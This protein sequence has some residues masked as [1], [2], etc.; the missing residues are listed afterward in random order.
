[1]ST[2]V[3]RF[4]LDM[5]RQWMPILTLVALCAVVGTVT[6]QFLT[7]DSLLVLAADTATLFVLATGQTFVIMLGGIDL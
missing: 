6:P 3:T 7:V 5:L 4:R 2:L 1:V